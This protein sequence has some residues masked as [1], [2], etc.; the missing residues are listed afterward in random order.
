M[1]GVE[2]GRRKS[3]SV[4]ITTWAA[5]LII[6]FTRQPLATRHCSR[7]S[8]YWA[9]D[10]PVKARLITGDVSATTLL[11]FGDQFAV[12]AAKAAVTH[13]HNVAGFRQLIH[14]PGNQ[15]IDR[16]FHTVVVQLAV[17]GTPAVHQFRQ[18]V[19]LAQVTPENPVCCRGTGNQGL[20]VYTLFHGVGA[21]LN[22]G[23]SEEHTSE[24]QSRPHLVCRLLLEKKKKITN[25]QK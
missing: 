11:Q 3:V 20:L 25:T 9:P 22:N 18:P 17:L 16:L 10:A 4:A 14:G 7:R 13:D 15:G 1:A 19:H 6:T 23:R 24:L 2:P 5:L 21:G 8:P 12:D